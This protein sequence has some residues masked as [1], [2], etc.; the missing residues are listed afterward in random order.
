MTALPLLEHAGVAAPPVP[1]KFRCL[2]FDPPWLE[3]GGGKSCRGAQRHYPLMKTSAIAALPVERVSADIAHLWLWVTDTYLLNGDALRVADAWGFRPVASFPW[4]KVK[5]GELQRGLG[6][7]S[8]KSHEYLLLCVRGAAM[9]PPT[10]VVG[11]SVIVAPRTTHSR[12]PP[13]SFRLIETVSPGPRLEGFGRAARPGWTVLGNQA[14]GQAR[15]DV[16]VDIA[17]QLWALADGLTLDQYL[18]RRARRIA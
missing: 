4:F 1:V 11:P 18:A 9:V 2:M 15:P 8:R 3:R 17:D 14:D 13:E 12:K 10:N 5:A 6:R 16:H 7:Y